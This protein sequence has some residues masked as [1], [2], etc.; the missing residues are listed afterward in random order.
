MLFIMSRFIVPRIADI[1]EQR[2]RKIDGYLNKAHNI[3]L[4]A[5]ESLKKYQDALAEATAEA[6]RSLAATQAELNAYMQAKQDELAAKLQKKIAAGEAEIAKS[7][8]EAM[9]RVKD[10]SEELAQTVV[11]KIGLTSI[12][13]KQLKEAV[14]TVEAEQ[15]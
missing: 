7:K 12:T 13:A 6:N 11:A 1:L 8:E 2:Q 5:E 9:A 15:K 4:E 3:R 10:M 14:K